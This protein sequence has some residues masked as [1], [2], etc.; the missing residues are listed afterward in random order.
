MLPPL[1][2]GKPLRSNSAAATQ[3][4]TIRRELR[5]V[6]AAAAAAAGWTVDV[7]VMLWIAPLS[8][9]RG[10]LVTIQEGAS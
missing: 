8:V 10:A 2:S 5:R 7:D 1:R 3:A 9:W 6:F 4:A